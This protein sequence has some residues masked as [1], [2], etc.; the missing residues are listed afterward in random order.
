MTDRRNEFVKKWLHEIVGLGVCGAFSNLHHGPIKR[1]ATSMEIVEES[2]RL[3]ERMFDDATR[4]WT[5]PD[6]VEREARIL[7]SRY[8]KE[9]YADQAQAATNKNDVIRIGEEIKANP[10]L[11]RVDLDE[12]RELFKALLTSLPSGGNFA[13]ANGEM[14]SSSPGETK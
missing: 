11:T 6:M 7:A 13:A 9:W 8:T 3:L 5:E 2:P 14:K 1:A 12:L 4:N 10:V